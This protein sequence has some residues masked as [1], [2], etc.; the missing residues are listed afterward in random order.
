MRKIQKAGRDGKSQVTTT[1]VTSTFRRAVKYARFLKV[2]PEIA[3]N[4]REGAAACGMSETHFAAMA[5]R[6]YFKARMTCEEM[7]SVYAVNLAADLDATP[8]Q[9]RD[10]GGPLGPKIG[11]DQETVDYISKL[12]DPARYG[13]DVVD[14]SRWWSDATHALKACSFAAVWQE[15]PKWPFTVELRPFTKDEGKMN[16]LLADSALEVRS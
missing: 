6:E 7:F 10:N 15:G 1:V 14:V 3:C 5:L 9:R 2:T 4:V 11:I 16:V 8:A 13:L 12:E